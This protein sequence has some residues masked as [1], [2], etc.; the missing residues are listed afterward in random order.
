MSDPAPQATR[1]QI[2]HGPQ[3]MRLRNSS[4]QIDL[5]KQDPFVSSSPR[6]KKSIAD[7]IAIGNHQRHRNTRVFQRPAN[8]ITDSLI[9]TGTPVSD[10]DGHDPPGLANE[11]VP[12]VATMV[13]D[14]VEGFEVLLESQL[15]DM[16]CQMFS[17]GFSFGHFAGNGIRMMLAGTM[18]GP[19]NATRPD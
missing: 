2:A 9:T 11:L 8:L 12:C 6:V 18:A 7:S 16:N 3:R 10:A 4:L 1:H 14:V 17:C 19:T 15:A 5:R 13:E